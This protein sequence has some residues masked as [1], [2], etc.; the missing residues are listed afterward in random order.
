MLFI[1]KFFL[2]VG[3]I[4]VSGLFTVPAFKKN[5]FITLNYLYLSPVNVLVCVVIDW[6]CLSFSSLDFFLFQLVLVP[7]M[8]SP[9]GT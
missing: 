1:T 3:K 2:I 8:L 9:S 7:H 4:H 6:D 5:I